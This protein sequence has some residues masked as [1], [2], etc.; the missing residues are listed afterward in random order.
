MLV[1]S[2]LEGGGWF[3]LNFGTPFIIFRA[4]LKF[5]F[6][7]QIQCFRQSQVMLVAKAKSQMTEK[8]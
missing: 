8:I 2:F 1:C 6:A 3:K 4:L 5:I 7:F